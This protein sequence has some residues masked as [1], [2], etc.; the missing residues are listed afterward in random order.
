MKKN[1]M[2]DEFLFDYRVVG[3]V[4]IYNKS[5]RREKHNG[6]GGG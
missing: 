6:C 2:R 3:I 1:T 4:D 5:R